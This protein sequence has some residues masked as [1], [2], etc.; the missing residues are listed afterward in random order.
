MGSDTSDSKIELYK[1][2]KDDPNRDMN[3][4]AVLN[5]NFNLNKLVPLFTKMRNSIKCIPKRV[6]KNGTSSFLTPLW[7]P[8]DVYKSSTVVFHN[9]DECPMGKD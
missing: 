1:S 8:S 5:I 7:D 4:V 3:T 9:L 2:W 6:G